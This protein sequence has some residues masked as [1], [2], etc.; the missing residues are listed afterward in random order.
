MPKYYIK[1]GD[2]KYIIDRNNHDEAIL[3]ALQVCKSKGCIAATK[4]C[5]SETGFKNHKLWKCYNTSDYLKNLK[6][7]K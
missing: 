3:R 4:I 7:K 1:S 6:D 5:I 2:I